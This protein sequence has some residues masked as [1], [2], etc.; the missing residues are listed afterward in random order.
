MQ[1]VRQGHRF[2]KVVHGKQACTSGGLTSRDIAYSTSSKKY[3][4][5]AASDAAKARVNGSAFALFAKA[6]EQVRKDYAIP[7]MTRCGGSTAEGQKF[8]RLTRKVYA[9]L[10][11]QQNIPEDLE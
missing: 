7:G 5:K 8:L 2:T 9:Q 6:R 1:S 3:V 4:S 10:K 11:A